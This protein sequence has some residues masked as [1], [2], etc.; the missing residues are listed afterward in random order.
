MT[1]VPHPHRLSR[2]SVRLAAVA[3][4]AAAVGLHAGCREAAGT[5]AEARP[6]LVE[7]V[8]AR[9]G[10]LPLEETVYG[11]VRAEN[12]VAVR[13]EIAAP[14][15]EVL[16][17]SGDPVE[18]EQVLVRLQDDELREELRQA[19][20]DVRLAAANAAEARARVA[21]LEAQVT[22][23]RALAAEDLVSAQ[24][25]ETQEARL[26][27]ARASADA[28][29]ARVEQ[30]EATADQRR[31]ALAK[32]RVRSPV[33]GHVGER[34]AEIGMVVDPGT[35]LFR[36]GNLDQV[37]VEVPLTE[38]ML[39][40]VEPGQPVFVSRRGDDG[41]PIEVTLT[42]ISPFL[43]E[44]SFTTI[45]E[46]DLDNTAGR[47]RPGMFVD[48]RILYGAS[49]RATLV[50]TSAVWEDP[51]SGERGVFVV[52]DA[53]GLAVPAAGPVESDP[54][55]REVV[56]R[57]VR[58]LAE[59]R[60]SIGVSGVDGGEWVVISGQHLL[61]REMQGGTGAAVGGGDAA[62]ARIRPASWGRV[63][64]L[65]EFQREDLL[66]GFLAKQRRVARALGAE[67]PA[68]EAEVQRALGAEP[69]GE[70]A[71]A[72]TR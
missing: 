54:A 1:L 64:A 69:G 70:P 62:E 67:I 6:P 5:P 68:S 66:E 58:I 8:E 36:V 12:Q 51:R 2:R 65:Q 17:R 56:F 25:L 28:A 18:R 50:P 57:S 60:E 23:T 49:E 48:V 72:E 3:A 38:R 11:T 37:I 14:I 26:E 53:A 45:G 31:S 52:R 21:E 30:A 63:V 19:E 41:G 42:R 59:G 39:G 47:L 71:P 43:E 61:R 46:I 10:A 15:A 24:E 29:A 13:P 34:N 40:Y 44:E 35:V 32:T 33:A 9:T 16:A 4:L 22:R 7:A 20:A 27:A 55:S